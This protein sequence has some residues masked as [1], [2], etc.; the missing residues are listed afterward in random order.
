MSLTVT[1]VD[2]TTL[3]TDAVV[4]AA[5]V[6]AAVAAGSSVQRVVFACFGREVLEEYRRAGVSSSPGAG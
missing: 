2:I 5:D 3:E 1:I 6:R 4:S